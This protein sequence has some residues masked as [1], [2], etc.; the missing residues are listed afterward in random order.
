MLVRNGCFST[1]SKFTE[2]LVLRR[3]FKGHIVQHFIQCLE[4]F[5]NIVLCPHGLS[6]EPNKEKQ[7]CNFLNNTYAFW[8]KNNYQQQVE[9]KTFPV[10]KKKG[11]RVFQRVVSHKSV[12]HLF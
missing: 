3:N 10:G 6:P 4:D 5:Q 12:L 7:F 8:D 1:L 2:L 9:L 11:K